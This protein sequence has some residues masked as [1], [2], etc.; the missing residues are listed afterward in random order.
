M[1]RH[2]ISR[3]GKVRFALPLTI[4]GTPLSYPSR[5]ALWPSLAAMPNAGKPTLLMERDLDKNP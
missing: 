4:M 3:A 1:A 5:S 2:L